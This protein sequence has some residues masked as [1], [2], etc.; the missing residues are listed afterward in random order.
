MKMKVLQID[1][2]LYDYIARQT[3]H[4]GESASAILRR[5]LKLPLDEFSSTATLPPL[6]SVPPTADLQQALKQLLTASRY[7]HEPTSIGRLMLVLSTLYAVDASAF[8]QAAAMTQG[9]TRRYF[10]GDQHTL[11]LGGLQTKPQQI[12]KTP[13]W[14][15]TNT[16]V[17]R[18]R[19]IVHSLLTTMQI[20]KPLIESLC[21]SL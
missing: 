18:K 9:R 16:N 13:Y 3:Q 8:A 19:A 21:D 11:E 4:I 10:A 12:P 5:L 15:I 20:P 1:A 6:P 14:V 7:R 17:A 2:E